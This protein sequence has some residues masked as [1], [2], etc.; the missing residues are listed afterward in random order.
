MK[1]YISHRDKALVKEE[2]DSQKGEKYSKACQA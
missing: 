2:D 1:M